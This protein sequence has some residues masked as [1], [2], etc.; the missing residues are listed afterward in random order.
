MMLAGCAS[1]APVSPKIAIDLA[2]VNA[3][4]LRGPATGLRAVHFEFSIPASHFE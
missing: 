1:A 2:N 3:E 4:G